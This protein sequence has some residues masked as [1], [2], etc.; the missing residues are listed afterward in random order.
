MF[1]KIAETG[2]WSAAIP[3]LAQALAARWSVLFMNPTN[4]RSLPYL[5][6]SLVRRLFASSVQVTCV[7]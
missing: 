2:V 5:E 6:L 7:C 1:Y 4:K 3:E